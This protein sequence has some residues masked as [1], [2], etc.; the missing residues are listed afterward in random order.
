MGRL[1]WMMVIMNQCPKMKHPHPQTQTVTVD[2]LTTKRKV[3]KKRKLSTDSANDDRPKKKMKL[4]AERIDSMK[5][6][7]LKEQCRAFDVKQS[8]KKAEIQ[9]RLRNFLK[10]E[11]KRKEIK[12]KYELKEEKEWNEI[13][14]RVKAKKNY[15][16][17]AMLEKNNVIKGGNKKEL[18]ERVCDCTLYGAYPSC[19]RC[20]G[21]KLKVTYPYKFGHK[22]HGL[23]FCKGYMDDDE[24]VYCRFKSREEIERPKW[25]E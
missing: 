20:G 2:Q 17:K 21:G 6:S 7:E 19:P 13:Y 15:E 3:A 12:K 4:S 10:N 1:F 16:L 14:E 24:F 8:G 9:E 22:G 5:V 23:W 25:K 18:I 11:A